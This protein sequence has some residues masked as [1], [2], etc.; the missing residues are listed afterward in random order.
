MFLIPGSHAMYRHFRTLLPFLTLIVLAIVLG[1]CDLDKSAFI[2]TA[3]STYAAIYKGDPSAENSIDW[4]SIQIN[5]DE[6]AQMAAGLITD[7]EKAE[8]H[9]SVLSRLKSFYT[10]KGWTPER[11]KDWRIQDRGTESAQV[12]ATAPNGGAVVMF[13]QKHQ[14]QKL[15]IKIQNR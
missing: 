15:I 11:M 3:Q 12:I 6:T 5:N 13:L 14:A 8:F 7:Y 4:R 9:R 10:S 2:K 1:G